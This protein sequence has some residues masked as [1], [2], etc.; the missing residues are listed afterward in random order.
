MSRLEAAL[1]SSGSARGADAHHGARDALTPLGL[2]K[3]RAYFSSAPPAP[4]GIDCDKEIGGVSA[5]YLLRVGRAMELEPTL[6]QALPLAKPSLD[7]PDRE[8]LSRAFGG[9]GKSTP[10][11][12]SEEDKGP[13]APAIAALRAAQAKEAG[14]ASGGSGDAADAEASKKRKRE[15]KE[16]KEKKRR[17]RDSEGG[18]APGTSQGGMTVSAGATS[19]GVSTGTGGS[20]ET[21]LTGNT[22]KMET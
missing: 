12:M 4:E 16:K 3:F 17:K 21:G 9:L 10:Y 1:G 18:H 11:A 2:A 14:T 8:A 22:V 15:R 13:V 19:A 7:A 5:G 20:G 6:R